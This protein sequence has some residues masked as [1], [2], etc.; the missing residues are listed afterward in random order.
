MEYIGIIV[1]VICVVGIAVA[2]YFLYSRMSSQQT[3]IDQLI[4]RQRSM[5]AMIFRPPPRQELNSLYAK[6]NK[7]EEDCDDCEVKPFELDRTDATLEDAVV[8]RPT[9]DEDR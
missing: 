2:G 3:T 8:E 9:R 1:G 7:S 5:E 6:E 4:A